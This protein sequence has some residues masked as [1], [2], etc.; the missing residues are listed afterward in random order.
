MIN[1]Q[2]RD[3]RGHA[4]HYLLPRQGAGVIL[5]IFQVQKNRAN[6][7]HV[8]FHRALRFSPMPVACN[9]KMSQRL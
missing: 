7:F 8:A 3:E 5:V 9:Y 2:T 4:A 6:Y 1:F